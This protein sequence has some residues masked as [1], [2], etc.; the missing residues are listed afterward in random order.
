MR[1]RPWLLVAA[2]PLLLLPAC[3]DGHI[4]VLGYTTKP[5]FDDHIRTVR[6]NIFE[7]RT[8]QKG[9]EFELQQSLTTEIEYRSKMK[10]VGMGCDADSEICGI[11]KNYTKNILNR[12]QQNQTREEETVLE[13][14]VVWRNLRTGEILTDRRH[15]TNPPIIPTIMPSLGNIPTTSPTTLADGVTPPPPP[16]VG[17]APPGPTLAGPP[18][19]NNTI[20]PGAVIV[21]SRGEVIP[22]LAVSNAA[23]RQKNSD[24]LARAIVD[25]MESPWTNRP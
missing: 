1:V 20:L 14:E 6:L 21:K 12:T 22:E 9:L 17:A 10:V 3:T 23:A 8:F 2:L 24:T 7:N 4:D 25:M 5:N 19:P 11:I 16:P 18:P 15:N 13:V